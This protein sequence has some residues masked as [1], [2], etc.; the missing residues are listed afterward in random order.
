MMLLLGR[1]GEMSNCRGKLRDL[2]L[3]WDDALPDKDLELALEHSRKADLAIC[4]GTSLRVRPANTIPMSTIKNGGNLVIVNLQKTP[5]D[6]YAQIKLQARCDDVMKS[7]MDAL[8]VEVK[9]YHQQNLHGTIQNQV[10]N[11]IKF[12]LNKPKITTIV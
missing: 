9:T 11:N 2:L 3:D 1:L 6:K 5:K 4:L 8:G 10:K 7:L 12:S